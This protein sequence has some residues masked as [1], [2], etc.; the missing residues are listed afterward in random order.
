MSDT[1]GIGDDMYA[2]SW[3][4]EDITFLLPLG[5]PTTSSYI[6]MCVSLCECVYVAICMYC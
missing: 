4:V 5:N 2:L 6:Y 1:E 3:Y